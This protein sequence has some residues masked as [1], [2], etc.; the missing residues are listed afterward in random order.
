MYCV[1]Q[2]DGSDYH[3]NA[4]APRLS[5]GDF[6]PT[7]MLLSACLSL[8]KQNDASSV[9]EGGNR[10]TSP[11]NAASYNQL[12]NHPFATHLLGHFVIFLPMCYIVPH[13]HDQKFTP[14][15]VAYEKVC[16]LV[17]VTLKRH[18]QRSA[19]RVGDIHK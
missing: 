2:E 13:N 11:I 6:L 3:T 14:L 7:S 1:R 4:L 9:K 8:F 12:Q 19:Y 18:A 16:R 17:R 10:S 5:V 15:R